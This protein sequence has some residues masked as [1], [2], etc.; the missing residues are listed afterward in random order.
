M[1]EMGRTLG[2]G[3]KTLKKETKPGEKQHHQDIINSNPELT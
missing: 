2:H 3:I 1:V